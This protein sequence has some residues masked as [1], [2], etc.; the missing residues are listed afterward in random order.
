VE[1]RRA[2]GED[3]V[4]EGDLPAPVDA[5]APR[6]DDQCQHTQ[7]ERGPMGD[8]KEAGGQEEVDQV[9]K[10]RKDL[11]GLHAGGRRGGR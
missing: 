10:R 8:G 6:V 2:G 3:A 1:G 7:G 4:E 9:R 11:G 5:E